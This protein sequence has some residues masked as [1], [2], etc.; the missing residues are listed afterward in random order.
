MSEDLYNKIKVYRNSFHGAAGYIGVEIT[1]VKKGWARGEILVK[2]HHL[3]PVGAVHGGILFTLADT[4]G[5]VA[6]WSHGEV[7]TTANGSIQFLNAALNPRKIIAEATE[8]KAGKNLLT[9]DIKIH[10]DSGKLICHTTQEYYSLHIPVT[11]KMEENNAV[12]K[13]GR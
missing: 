11:M 1:D 10:D 5:G 4:V 9:Y 8:L 12:E 7:V 13:A 2:N 3:N 6:A